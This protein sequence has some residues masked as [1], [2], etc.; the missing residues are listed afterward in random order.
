MDSSGCVWT[1]RKRIGCNSRP[2]SRRRRTAVPPSST[3]SSPHSEPKGRLELASRIARVHLRRTAGGAG[4]AAAAAGRRPRPPRRAARVQS[5]ASAKAPFAVAPRHRHCRQAPP[6]VAADVPI[7]VRDA[8]HLRFVRGRPHARP[9]LLEDRE[10]LHLHA[11]MKPPHARPQVVRRG[12]V[13]VAGSVRNVIV[14]CTAS[15]MRER[16]KREEGELF[17]F[18]TNLSTKSG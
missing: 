15:A 8:V 1:S 16:G 6:L 12:R 5:L 13:A 7:S 3:W 18:L 4:P 17:F 9:V 14:L 2:S 11:P 10:L